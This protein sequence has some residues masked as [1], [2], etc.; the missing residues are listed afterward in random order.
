MG[1]KLRN[2]ELNDVY[3]LPNV[4]WVI[5]YRIIIWAGHTAHMVERRGFWRGNLRKRD[6]LEDPG[7]DGGIILKWIFRKWDREDGLA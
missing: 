6:H 5:K 2:K 1:K 4:I 7:V 3:S